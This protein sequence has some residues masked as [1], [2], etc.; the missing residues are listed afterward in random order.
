MHDSVRGR[1]CPLIIETLRSTHNHPLRGSFTFGY[2]AGLRDQRYGFYLR[3]HILAGTEAQY[4][5][6]APRDPNQEFGPAISMAEGYDD[7]DLCFI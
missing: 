7:V 2:G 1:V 3:I 6:C 5:Q 4:L